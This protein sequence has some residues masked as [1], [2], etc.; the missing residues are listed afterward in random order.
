[1][2]GRGSKRSGYTSHVTAEERIQR[3]ETSVQQ[4][5]SVI[6]GLPADVLYREPQPGEWP[7]MSTLAHLQELLPYWAHQAL[8]VV[9]DPDRPF[10]RTHS[11]P[12]RI[13]AVEEH[14][15]DSLD[16]MVS[17]IRVSLDE[18]LATLRSLP[19]EG[20]SCVGHS[21][22]RGTMTVEQIV[23]A[24]LVRHVEE[25]AAQTQSTLSALGASAKS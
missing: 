22:S 10:G 1:M 12:V 5:I 18:C 15:H 25:H 3:I 2:A 14:G 19:L 21:P 4:L 13:G 9:N 8:G 7:V 17:R 16:A 20:W 11:D 23:D 6:E 24:F